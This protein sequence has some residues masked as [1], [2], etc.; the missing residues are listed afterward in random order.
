MNTVIKRLLTSPHHRNSKTLTIIMSPR[1][2][3]KYG[4]PGRREGD[5]K[6]Y[7]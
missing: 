5:R 1:V 7:E 3:D 2:R 4:H 6:E